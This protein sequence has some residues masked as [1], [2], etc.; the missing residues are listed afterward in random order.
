MQHPT[1]MT[2]EEP[3]DEDL[4]LLMKEVAKE[5]KEKAIDAKNKFDKALLDEVKAAKIWYKNHK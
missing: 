2:M 1:L 3:S 5:A 4:S